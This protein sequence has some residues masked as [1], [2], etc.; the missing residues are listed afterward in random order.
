MATLHHTHDGGG[1]I[2]VKGAP[3]RILEMC[4]RKR[5]YGGDEPL[6]VAYWQRRMEE[7]AG[8]G[9]RILALASR[10]AT[11]SRRELRFEEVENNLILVGLFGLADPPRQEAMEAVVQCRS[12]GIQVKMITGDHAATATAIAAQLGMGNAAAVL[13]GQDLDALT[14]RSLQAGLGTRTSSREPAHSIS[15]VSW[16]RCRPPGMS[17]Q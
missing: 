9:Q 17:S 1:F 13:T 5:G 11:N 10:P 16:R 12:A 6:D 14:A 2:Y 8:R 4:D 7:I 15:Y 3:E